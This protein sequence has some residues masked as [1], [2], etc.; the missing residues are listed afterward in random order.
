[1]AA[2]AGLGVAGIATWKIIDLRGKVNDMRAE[3]KAD[4]DEFGIAEA[5]ADAVQ[6]RVGA[7]LYLLIA[8]GLTAAVYITYAALK[9]G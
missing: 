2:L 9:R 3:M 6:V 1:L 5:M 8:A 7:G 4:G